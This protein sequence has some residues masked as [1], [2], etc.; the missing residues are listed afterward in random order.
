MRKKNIITIAVSVAIFLVAA[1]LLYRYLFP[2]TSNSGIK[3][4]APHPVNPNFNQTQLEVLKSKK[5]YTQNIK[6]QSSLESHIAS[7]A[8]GFANQLSKRD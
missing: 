3:Y 7:I 4:E 1:A 2:P 5:D 8:S 6:P